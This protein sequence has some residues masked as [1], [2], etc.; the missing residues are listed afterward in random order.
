MKKIFVSIRTIF[1]VIPI[2]VCVG[3]LGSLIWVA[4]GKYALP[5]IT[6]SCGKVYFNPTDKMIHFANGYQ[7]IELGKDE[8]LVAGDDI[9][10]IDKAENDFGCKLFVCDVE[11]ID[12]DSS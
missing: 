2:V 5:A 10:G 4:L 11:W 6:H 8:Y 3:F 12:S 9:D 1:A 7:Y